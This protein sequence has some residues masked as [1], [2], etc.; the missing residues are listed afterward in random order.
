MSIS[1]LLHESFQQWW[2]KGYEVSLSTP[3]YRGCFG[4][5]LEDCGLRRNGRTQLKG[6]EGLPILNWLSLERTCAFVSDSPQ[7]CFPAHKEGS[8]SCVPCLEVAGEKLKHQPW[9]FL[10]TQTSSRYLW[11]LYW[12]KVYSVSDFPRAHHKGGQQPLKFRDHGIIVP[13]FF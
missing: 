12:G 4:I 7:S 10:A 3:L 11:V 8:Q 6:G 2:S 5:D 9:G 1:W 13:E